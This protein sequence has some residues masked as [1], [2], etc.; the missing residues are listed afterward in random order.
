MIASP[1]II[2]LFLS[3]V[4]WGQ[5]P[6]SKNMVE[7]RAYS[8][9]PVAFHRYLGWAICKDCNFQGNDLN[10]YWHTIWTYDD[11]RK[12]CVWYGLE[13]THFVFQPHPRYCWLKRGRVYFHDAYPEEN[14]GLHGGIRCDVVKT[15]KI[16]KIFLNKN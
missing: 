13:C 16:T 11:C 7:S 12:T 5:S 2:S 15:G 6:V 9:P 4:I 14:H 3:L 8:T 10:Y 1:L